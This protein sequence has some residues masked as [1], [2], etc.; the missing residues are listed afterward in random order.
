MEMLSAIYNISILN[1]MRKINTIMETLTIFISKQRYC[2][3]SIK[4]SVM[5]AYLIYRNIINYETNQLDN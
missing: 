2:Y 5:I 3:V 1:I 4:L